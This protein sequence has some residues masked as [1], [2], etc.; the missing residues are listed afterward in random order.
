M[1]DL[2]FKSWFCFLLGVAP[3]VMAQTPT[4]PP[5]GSVAPQTL[6]ESC[7]FGIRGAVAGTLIERGETP[8]HIFAV[9]RI[10][11][12]SVRF[13]YRIKT[14]R[15][16]SATEH[17]YNVARVRDA[18]RSSAR[19]TLE[20][21][22]ENTATMIFETTRCQLTIRLKAENQAQMTRKVDAVLAALS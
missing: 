22:N 11:N 4:E 6:A 3:S 12:E 20:N 19:L 8:R 13:D 18:L 7:G 10:G 21:Q 15:V 16:L 2:V 17:V 9:Y 5:L 1:G 14:K